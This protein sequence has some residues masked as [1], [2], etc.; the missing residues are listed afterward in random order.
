[1]SKCAD[2]KHVT[3]KKSFLSHLVFCYLIV[4]SPN[5]LAINSDPVDLL[6]VQY[7]NLYSLYD[8]FPSLRS[9]LAKYASAQ[10]FR[11]PI[12]NLATQIHELIHVESSIRQGFFLDGEYFEPYLNPDHWPKITNAEIRPQIRPEEQSVI[13][14]VYMANTPNNGLGNIIDEI[15]AYSQVHEFICKNESQ[16]I[17]KQRENL[18]GFLRVLEAYL[19]TLRTMD[20]ESYER[21]VDDAQGAGAVE[22]FVLKAWEALAKCGLEIPK[23]RFSEAVT[24]IRYHQHKGQQTLNTANRQ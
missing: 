8:R 20:R 6:K 9:T 7:P 15:N 22:T 21:L 3:M 5:G 19:R 2:F 12:V 14:S 1:M 4:L 18:V 13:V 17:Q 24:F 23:F 11:A 16:S 10:G